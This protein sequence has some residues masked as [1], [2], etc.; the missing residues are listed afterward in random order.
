ML[1]YIYGDSN[2]FNSQ[3]LIIRW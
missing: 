3:L 2:S 1:Q